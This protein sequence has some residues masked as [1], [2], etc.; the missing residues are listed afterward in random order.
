MSAVIQLWIPQ[1][2][3]NFLSEQV[4]TS[5]EDFG[6][7]KFRVRRVLL[8]G[9]LLDKQKRPFFATEVKQLKFIHVI[10]KLGM[11]IR[12]RPE[13]LPQCLRLALTAAATVYFGKNKQYFSL[14]LWGFSIR[15]TVKNIKH[16]RRSYRLHITSNR[17]FTT[18]GIKSPYVNNNQ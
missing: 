14:N 4:L 17:H 12:T 11:M 9:E 2:S 1:N 3:G 13:I 5:E 18:R 7:T 16:K 15:S 10:R 8:T 6:S